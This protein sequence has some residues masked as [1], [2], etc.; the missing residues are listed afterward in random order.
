MGLYGVVVVTEFV[1]GV[2]WGVDEAHDAMDLLAFS[3]L[4]PV[5]GLAQ[6]VLLV[7]I[8]VSLA[9]GLRRS[10]AST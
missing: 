10:S 3:H 9:R 5:L 7:W 6:L 8:P 2:L 1:Q 4:S